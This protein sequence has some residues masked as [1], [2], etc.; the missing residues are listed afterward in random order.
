[1]S[2][3][4]DSLIILLN[5]LDR[6]E[7]VTVRSLIED[8]QMSERTVHRYLV[9]LRTAFPISYDRHTGSYA[10]ED[11]YT[12]KRPDLSREEVI[13]FA[14]AK[15]MLT[16]LG[17]GMEKGLES[18]ARK[19]SMASNRPSEGISIGP[20]QAPA[21]GSQYIIPLQQALSNYQSLEIVY[22]RLYDDETTKRIVDP[23]YLF[24]REGFWNLRGYCRLRKALRTF[25]LDRIVVLKL[26]GRYFVP[27][28]LTPH[29][30]LPGSFGSYLDDEE[31]EVVVR[32]DKEI[33]P[34]VTRKKWHQ[35]QRDA[36]LPD[37]RLELRFVVNG[38]EDIR[39]WLYQWI[40]YVEVVSPEELRET[41]VAELSETVNRHKGVQ[42]FSPP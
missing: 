18:I 15:N 10:F 5:K 23:Y 29:D 31:V 17:P 8:L 30:E 41:L 39:K 38:T 12:L 32:F 27:M 2:Y 20:D 35:S 26:T 37:G 24:F 42:G 3:K 13:T 1:M 16:N 11:G 7:K 19:I 28:H 9:T 34:Y 33:K 14:L 36:E 22:R 21:S 4:F 6:G 25:A 40:P